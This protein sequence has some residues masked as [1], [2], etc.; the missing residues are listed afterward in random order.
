MVAFVVII[1]LHPSLMIK[2]VLDAC[3][4]KEFIDPYLNLECVCDTMKLTNFP[5]KYFMSSH[6][7]FC[8]LKNKQFIHCLISR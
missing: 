2:I 1:F 6:F 8:N 4:R 5:Y 7:C 3:H